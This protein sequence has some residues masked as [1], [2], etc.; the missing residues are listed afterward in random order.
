M[1]N[2]FFLSIAITALSCCPFSFIN[3]QGGVSINAVGAA[4]DNSAGLDVNFTNKGE[5]MPRMSTEQRNGIG[6]PATGLTIFNTD[7]G[8]YNYNAGTPGSPSWATVNASNVLVAAVSIAA[9]PV[10][11]TCAGNSITFNAIPA[12]GINAPNYQWQVNGG[13]VGTNSSTYTTSSLNNGDVVTCILTTNEACVSGSPATSNPITMLV[14]IVPVITG[15]TA[16]GF[17]NGSAVTLSASANLGTINWYANSTGGSSLSSGASFTISG[18]NAS[19][20]YYVDASANGCTTPSRT[21]VT[22]TFY[23]NQP[24]QPGSISGPATVNKNDTAT[25]SVSP[26][27]Y[28]ATYGWTVI[29]GTITTGQGTNSILVTWGD[30]SVIG[31][32]SVNA[33]NLCGTSASQTINIGVEE[34]V[35]SYTGSLQTF[36]APVTGNITI[37]AAGAQGGTG[38]YAGGYG[39]SMQGT[40]SLNQGQVLNIL[41][42]QQGATFTQASGGGG[43]GTFVVL[44]GS[45]TPLI[46]AGGGG[47]G[48]ANYSGGPGLAGTTGGNSTGGNTA[49]GG[50]ANGG[51]AAGGEYSGAGGGGGTCCDGTSN[52]FG[53]GLGSD[54]GAGFTGNGGQGQNSALIAYSY[55]NGGGG[56]S[57]PNYYSSA[58]TY[59]GYG[60]GGNGCSYS[61]YQSGGGGGGGYT[62]GGGGGGVTTGGGGGGGGS[63]NSGTN[64][65]N[66]QG[67][68]AGNGQVVITW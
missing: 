8:V 31:S 13:N 29:G 18:L 14:N 1:K 44:N 6:N 65:N 40:F 48:G 54:G 28:T 27:A 38:E 17:C 30:S 53:G 50:T 52:S 16:S 66:Q 34:Q 7:C 60:G 59:G 36:T 23:P 56:G 68:Q 11:A 47:G 10:G 22:A 3:A 9:S 45:N 49:Y 33:T 12:A 37:T 15:T 57:Q 41:V 62:G 63:Y 58:N 32:I 67:L 26:V 2:F 55:V 51:G 25:Y 61:G 20:T 46:I 5:L 42:G 4:P 35:Y 24:N 19:T 21:A 39:A 64:Q 43:G